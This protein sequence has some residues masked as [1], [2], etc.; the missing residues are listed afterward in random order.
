MRDSEH[1]I[2][3]AKFDAADIFNYWIVENPRG[4]SFF[5]DLTSCDL[6]G[7]LILEFVAFCE[8]RKDVGGLVIERRA[9]IGTLK[10][11]RVG[12]R[13]AQVG[14]IRISYD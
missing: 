10:S 8:H 6:P 7:A 13:G 9:K 2:H 14:S 12:E 1:K 3:H 4:L 11:D 5:C